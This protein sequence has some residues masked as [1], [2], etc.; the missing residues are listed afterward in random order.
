M[1]KSVN[2]CVIVGNG[3]DLA[4]DLGTDAKVF[5][6]GFIALHSA[7]DSP[8]GRLA[9]Q[10]RC[11]GA[12]TWAD[13]EQKLGE[14]AG[15]LSPALSGKDLELEYLSAKE[16]IEEDLNVFIAEREQAA[17]VDHIDTCSSRCID[18]LCAWVDSLTS[19]DREKVRSA[20]G[21]P[22]DVTFYFV[23]LNYTSILDQVVGLIRIGNYQKARKTGVSSFLLSEVIHAHGD[24]D[25]NPICGVNDDSQI[26]NE[27]LRSSASVLDTV[28]KGQTQALFGDMS[29]TR[30]FDLISSADVVLIYGCS[31]GPTDRRWWKAVVDWM[32]GSASRFVVIASYGLEGHQRTAR[33]FRD[34]TLGLREKLF[35]SAG[36]ADDEDKEDLFERVLIIPSSR[37]FKFEETSNR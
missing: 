22:L 12:E 35:E 21:L 3:F 26:A 4:A 19:M 15:C 23:T 18:S 1:G 31:M 34:F 32:K 20:I 25:G 36:C 27:E 11:D 30:A 13:F 6:E 10:M 5:V 28:V 29:D 16:S 8:A 17:D 14:Y 37:I 33:S 2:V 9:A 24:L 7:E